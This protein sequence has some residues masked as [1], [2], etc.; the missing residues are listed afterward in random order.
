M[1]IKKALA[2]FVALLC[3]LSFSTVAGYA[4]TSSLTCSVCNQT[5][6]VNSP[7]ADDAVTYEAYYKKN[8]VKDVTSDKNYTYAGITGA[9]VYAAT[10]N[11]KPLCSNCLKTM[12]DASTSGEGL[13]KSATTLLK[14]SAD[15]TYTIT[16]PE[17]V[18]MKG[19]DSGPG[20]YTGELSMTLKGDIEENAS[21][22][23][24]ITGGT[25][26]N[27]AGNTAAVTVSNQTKSEWSRSDMLNNG[28]DGTCTVSATLEAGH[29]TGT[30]TFSCEKKYK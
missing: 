22:A 30:A 10:I 6:S 13:P 20:V 16:V 1:K 19:A 14:A 23:V 18:T 26:T 12:V 9:T 11:G 15:S 27:T 3:S 25:M 28:T 7:A 5:Y 2:V 24:S 21:I 29:W 8:S 4:T 17:T